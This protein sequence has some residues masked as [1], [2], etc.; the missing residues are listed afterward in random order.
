MKNPSRVEIA[1]NTECLAGNEGRALITCM[2]IN[3]TDAPVSGQE[4]SC[5][6]LFLKIIISKVIARRGHK[7]HKEHDH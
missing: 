3:N 4:S 5:L 1:N 6:I 7:E 2:Q